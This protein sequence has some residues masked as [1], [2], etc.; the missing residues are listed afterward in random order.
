[1]SS[2]EYTIMAKVDVVRDFLTIIT[3]FLTKIVD[4]VS[5]V[6][7]AVFRI[8]ENSFG[9]LITK[10]I[11]VPFPISWLFLGLLLIITL[12]FMTI[13][14]KWIEIVC[15][16]VTTNDH[17]SVFMSSILL[18]LFLLWVFVACSN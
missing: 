9:A 8:I 12:F 2:I 7:D 5:T 17:E 11:T 6:I 14:R 15:N 4:S 16:I 18:W 1:M 10:S 3:R 13:S